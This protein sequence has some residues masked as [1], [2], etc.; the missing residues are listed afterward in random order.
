[1]ESCNPHG[2]VFSQQGESSGQGAEF[3][4]REL[5]ANLRPGRLGMTPFDAGQ[6]EGVE[7]A[8]VLGDVGYALAHGL[9]PQSLE[10]EAICFD[11]GIWRLRV[12]IKQ[13]LSSLSPTHVLA[14]PQ[15]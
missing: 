1:M 13:S 8:G 3:G 10:E 9:L 2:F 11:G 14:I 7:A 15:W 4:K 6:A 5:F 12:D